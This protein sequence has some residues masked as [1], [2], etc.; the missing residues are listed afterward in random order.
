MP[1]LP[2]DIQEAFILVFG[3]FI[4]WLF[5]FFLGVGLLT[6]LLMA[7]SRYWRPAEVIKVIIIGW[8]EREE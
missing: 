1:D 7:F 4:G 3:P 5:V 8:P 2:L 6:V